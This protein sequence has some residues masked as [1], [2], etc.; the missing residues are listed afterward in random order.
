MVGA[1]CGTA[2][3]AWG[4]RRTMWG[5]RHLVRVGQLMLCIFIVVAMARGNPLDRPSLR[6]FTGSDTSDT[7]TFRWR[8]EER[9]PYFW[10][11][12]QQNP[13]FGVGSDSDQALGTVANT[14]HNGFLSLAV[15]SGLPA[16]AV[17]L[18]LVFASIGSGWRAFRRS[19]RG[20]PGATGLVA[21]AGVISILVHN[22]VDSTMTLAFVS[23]M[24]WMLVA[25]AAR[26]EREARKVEMPVAPRPE[27]SAPVVLRAVR[28]A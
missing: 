15:M 7:G 5:R 3:I 2:L 1:V 4:L 23:Q 19:P 27:V 18:A 26:M 21:A 13:W 6:R 20:W 17:Y 25:T 9:W 24:F 28:R 11:K 8:L 16:L 14:P 22:L 12:V 10:N